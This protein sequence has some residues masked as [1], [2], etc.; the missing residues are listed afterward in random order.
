[1]SDVALDHR[2]PTSD[3]PSLGIMDWFHVKLANVVMG[4]SNGVVN[5][6]VH[7]PHHKR[8][9]SLTILWPQFICQEESDES[10]H[11]AAYQRL[12]KKKVGARVHL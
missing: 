11:N 10:V 8:L 6:Q 3:I 7:V 4:E 5:V 1:M 2:S 12:L 9:S